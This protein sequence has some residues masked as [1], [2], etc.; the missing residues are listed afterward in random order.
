VSDYNNM[1]K[2][3]SKVA[4]FSENG[5]KICDVHREK[6]ARM[7]RDGQAF[8][9]NRG[10]FVRELVV[11]DRGAEGVESVPGDSRRTIYAE[12]LSGG[13]DLVIETMAIPSRVVTTLPCRAYH[14]K[15]IRLSLRPLYETVI[16]ETTANTR[17][18][19]KEHAL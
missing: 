10:K 12:T 19:P 4:V 18:V 16:R 11:P 5:R 9:R 13:S 1:L 7:C 2:F 14:L 6:A 8:H 15:D 3:A 17:G